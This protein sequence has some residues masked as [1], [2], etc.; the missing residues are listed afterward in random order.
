MVLLTVVTLLS[1]T[2][3]ELAPFKTGSVYLLTTFI[4]L[5]H[6]QIPSAAYSVLSAYTSSPL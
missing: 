2:S 1:V 4:H 5:T 3:P 6:P